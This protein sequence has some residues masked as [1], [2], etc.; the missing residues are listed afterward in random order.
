MH[1]EIP[2]ASVEKYFNTSLTF[3]ENT[4]LIFFF[5][6][7]TIIVIFVFYDFFLYNIVFSL[8]LQD[9]TNSYTFAHDTNLTLSENTSI[10][11]CPH[12]HIR[13]NIL[14]FIW[15]HPK[16]NRHDFFFQEH[17]SNIF[18]Y[19]SCQTFFFFFWQ[20]IYNIFLQDRS[21]VILAF[22]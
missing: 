19:K 11:F 16:S 18:G 20:H 3:S 2:L 17:L 7:T 6:Y 5:Y 21:R 14:F 8:F 22:S 1:L 10:T 15:T 4:T 9:K 12:N 13:S